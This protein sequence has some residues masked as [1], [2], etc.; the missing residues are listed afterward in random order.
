MLYTKIKLEYDS[1]GIELICKDVTNIFTKAIYDIT[2]TV[3]VH[4]YRD[5]IT[6][7]VIYTGLD[8]ENSVGKLTGYFVDLVSSEDAMKA[9]AAMTDE[10]KRAYIEYIESAKDKESYLRSDTDK[11]S[12]SR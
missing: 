8:P 9:M 11:K 12:P 4:K 5:L 1:N 2:N 6:G 3:G 7:E 10:E